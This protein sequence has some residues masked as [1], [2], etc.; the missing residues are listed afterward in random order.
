MCV[1][2]TNQQTRESILERIAN[3]KL[4]VPTLRTQRS[5]NLDFHEVAVWELRAALEAAFEAGRSAK[6]SQS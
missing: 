6:E 3:D 5:D 4:R 1:V 2:S